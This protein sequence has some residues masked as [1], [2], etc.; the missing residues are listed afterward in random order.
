MNNTFAAN[1]ALKDAKNLGF[2]TYD[3]RIEKLFNYG[4][5]LFDQKRFKECLHIQRK[6]LLIQPKNFNSTKKY[7]LSLLKIQ[8]TNYR[9]KAIRQS[10]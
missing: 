4:T 2:Q 10:F 1:T 5:S 8:E 3:L 7:C 9:T 6:I